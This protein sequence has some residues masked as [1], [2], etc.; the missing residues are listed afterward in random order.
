MPVC[1]R[2]W[3]PARLTL[4]VVRPLREGCRHAAPKRS[5]AVR[6]A[7]L[8]NFPLALAAL[9]ACAAVRAAASAVCPESRRENGA[10]S[11]D[12]IGWRSAARI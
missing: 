3:N 11:E 1:A 10:A 7:K 9:G 6:G 8:L 5:M 12:S 2:K 4:A